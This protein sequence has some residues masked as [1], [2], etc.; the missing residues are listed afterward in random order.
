VGDALKAVYVS[1]DGALDPLG[2]SQ[3]VP[4][5]VGLSKRGVGLTL[6]SFE[7]PAAWRD[8][9]VRRALE[10]RLTESRIRWRPLSYH[11]R[12]RLPATAWDIAHGAGCVYR[13][14]QRISADLVHCRGDVAMIMARTAPLPARTRLLYDVRGLFSDERVETG[15]WPRG[16]VIDRAVRRAEAA[17]LRR[18]DGV[19][20][21][22]EH[23]REILRARR[24]G[25][26]ALRV[27]PTCADLSSFYPRRRE[28]EPE[29]GL[30]YSGSLGTWYMAPEMVAF[31]RTAA[32]VIPG[33]VLFLTRDAEKAAAA[34]AGGDW[35]EVRGADPIDVPAWLRRTRAL[36]F[37]IQ[38]TPA[39]R[40]SCPTKL[41]EALATGLPVAAN[42]GVGDL[43][44]VLERHKVGVVVD[45]FDVAAYRRAAERMAQLL[46][47]PLLAERCR[48]LAREHYSLETGVEGY[49][50]L[51]SAICPSG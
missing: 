49:Y 9:R 42:R 13:E 2:A 14:A 29:Y 10:A 40:A 43:D 44:D 7:K 11:L 16:G 25:I 8:R 22:T 27:I 41:A 33:R 3:V 1:Y 15:S 23:A 39:K 45:G 34:G 31:A 21:L 4:Y 18:A 48:R 47:D 19:V 24:P 20:V 37:F 35:V 12:P 38:P 32:E 17:N 30:A 6:L 28:D 51:Y 50:S 46:R 36:F 5:L 26:P